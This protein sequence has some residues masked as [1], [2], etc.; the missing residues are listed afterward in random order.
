MTGPGDGRAPAVVLGPEDRSQ[1]A[2]RV[3]ALALEG[4]LEDFRRHEPAV[5]EGRDADAL[6]DYRVALRRTRSVLAAG[7]RVYPA[8]ELELLRALTAGLAAVTSP[9]RDLD[10]LLGEFDEYASA[11]SRHCEQG[12]ALLREE[13]QRT[14]AAAH[15]ELVASIEGDTHPVL[16][17]RWQVMASVHRIGGGEPGPDALRP[18]GE[19]VDEL[20][21]HAFDRSVRRGGRLLASEDPADWHE[22]RKR[23]KRLR[24]LMASFG[25]LYP[26]GAFDPMPEQL[27]KLQDRFGALQ[28]H[29]AQ[30]ATIEASGLRLGGRAALAAGAMSAELHRRIERDLRRCRKSWT[31]MESKDVRRSVRKALHRD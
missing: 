23:L 16:L 6:H 30:S 1:P 25:G 24:Y 28:D 31:A 27:S 5:V 22:L 14:R 20:I 13:L 18:A 10:V 3:F 11:L 15:G 12:L 2:G 29:V 19:V 26:E 9:V 17:R 21:G 4:L 8:E 7:K